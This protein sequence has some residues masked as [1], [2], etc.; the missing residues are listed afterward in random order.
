M[1]NNN[2][3]NSLNNSVSNGTKSFSYNQYAKS[4]TNA[5]SPKKVS[6]SEFSSAKDMFEK[7]D[8]SS[9]KEQLSPVRRVGVSVSTLGSSPARKPLP[10]EVQRTTTSKIDWKP[11]K[12]KTVSATETKQQDS[13]VSIG[14]RSPRH[15]QKVKYMKETFIIFTVIIVIDV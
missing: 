11:D 8:S 3:E 4:T 13:P 1:E 5:V 2:N 14:S 12:T 7:K 9:E 15:E 6:N 10:W